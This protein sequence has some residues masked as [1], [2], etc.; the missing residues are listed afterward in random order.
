MTDNVQ[1]CPVEHDGVPMTLNLHR[2]S[3]E[4]VALELRDH[5]PPIRSISFTPDMLQ[6]VVSGELPSIE[7]P[8]RQYGLSRVGDRVQIVFCDPEAG[9]HVACDV[10]PDDLMAAVAK[11]TGLGAFFS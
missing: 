5:L 8:D 1:L 11:V 4:L 2:I 3:K 6:Q 7:S 9:I 10:S